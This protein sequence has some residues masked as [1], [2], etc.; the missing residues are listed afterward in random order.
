MPPLNP[1][2]NGG[3]IKTQTLVGLTS[4]K[5]VLMSSGLMMSQ[6]KRGEVNKWS[7]TEAAAILYQYL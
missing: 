6:M 5:G 2:E 1:I 3:G 7:P 4:E